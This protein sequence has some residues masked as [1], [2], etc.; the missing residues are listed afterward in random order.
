MTGEAL[1]EG[2]YIWSFDGQEERGPVSTHGERTHVFQTSGPHIIKLSIALVGLTSPISCV[3]KQ[4]NTQEGYAIVYPRISGTVRDPQ[5]NGVP[6]I[7]VSADCY[8][9]TDVTDADGRY[10]IDVFYAWSGTVVPQHNGY[11]FNLPERRYTKLEVDAANQNFTATPI[12]PA[13]IAVSGHVR[14]DAANPISGVVLAASGD[15]GTATTDA[16]GFYEFTFEEGWSGTITPSHAEYTFSPTDCSVTNLTSALSGQDFTASSLPSDCSIAG[17]LLDSEGVELHLADVQFSATGGLVTV[18]EAD[19]S[20]FLP[21]T[22][23]WTGTIT[24][25]LD[26]YTFEPAS[27]TYGNEPGCDE[28]AVTTDVVN[29]DF[30]VIV[31]EPVG[32]CVTS[33][34]TWQN[35]QIDPQTGVFTVEFDAIPNGASIDGL[36]ALSM[37]ESTTWSDCAVIVRFNDSDMIDARNGGSYAADAAL[38][39]TADE[40]YHFRLTVN[41]PAHTYSVFV[42]PEGSTEVTIAEDFAFRTEQSGV[43]QLDHWSL[44]ASIGSHQ[45]CD[46]TVETSGNQPPI[47][48]AGSDQAVTDTDESGTVTSPDGRTSRNTSGCSTSA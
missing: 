39:Y 4:N 40:S 6:G 35:T 28:P 26:G 11:T 3:C 33:S 34:E 16:Q 32:D 23:G 2:E 12:A 48:D 41:V 37:G 31:D 14:D 13:Q 18:S 30:V 7:V 43:A 25:S 42:T 22:E 24:P 47:A 44:Q 15:A 29:A 10:E 8:K 20:Y 45:V 1:P 38:A 19:G 46:L 27:V 17:R 21:V 9:A 5:G 36:T